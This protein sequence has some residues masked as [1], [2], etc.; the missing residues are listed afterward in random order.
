[1]K[2]ILKS[3]LNY[4]YLNRFNARQS[5]L[6]PG[7]ESCSETEVTRP[8]KEFSW[9]YT[10]RVFITALTTARQKFL[11]SGIWIQCT[12]LRRFFNIDLQHILPSEPRVPSG[13]AP[14]RFSNQ[15]LLFTAYLSHAC[16]T[17]WSS[18]PPSYDFSTNIWKFSDEMT[19]VVRINIFGCF[20][21]LNT[22]HVMPEISCLQI[23]HLIVW[24]P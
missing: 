5:D 1:M 15:T 11:A 13:F 18:L 7:P 20:S 24:D 2:I 23:S 4:T 14:F 3:R 19:V 22:V 9:F 17:A 8:I 12:F 6:T 10:L 16:R 21:Q